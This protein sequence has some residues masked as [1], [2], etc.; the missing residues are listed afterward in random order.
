MLAVSGA[1]DPV[2]TTEFLKTIATG[3]R[4]GALVELPDTSHVAPAERPAE[5]AALID[6][7]PSEWRPT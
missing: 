5:V 6:V 7:T 1:D 3:V 2:T 4:R